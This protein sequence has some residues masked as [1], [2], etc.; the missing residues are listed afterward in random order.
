MK[1]PIEIK[2]AS[3][4]NLIA[5]GAVLILVLILGYAQL[6]T[7]YVVGIFWLS[8][9]GIIMATS[10]NLCNGFLGQMALGHAGF[11]LIG[12]YTSALLSLAM[13]RADILAG[14][15]LQQFLR[16]VICLF[17]SG[18]LATIFGILVGIPALRLRG[19]YLAIITL[20]FGEIIRVVIQG[21]PWAGADGLEQGSAS[22]V[23]YKTGLGFN[24]ATKSQYMVFIALLTILCVAIIF[25]FIRSRF[26]RA[27]ISIRDDEI[28]S[29]ASGID[30]TRYKVMGFAFSAFFAGIAGS[31]FAACY[32][33]LNT[34]NMGFMAS[35]NYFVMV[36]FGGMGSI[37][38][39][40]VSAIGLTTLNESLR[41]FNE[42]RMLVYSVVL[43][44]MMIFRPTGLLGTY[45]FSLTQMLKKFS[46][47]SAKKS[48]NEEVEI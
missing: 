34:G 41:S 44:L 5:C 18:L 4:I 29:E 33:S 46:G 26:G 22:P 47:G 7:S 11:M 1:M 2:K 36:V 6:L 24:N 8:C 17:A 3:R 27:V 40:I 15:G 42:Y 28:A 31:I 13:V 32:S 30:T 25:T 12:A 38:G 21:I 37:T 43:V 19:D 45:E 9:I 16:F 14:D 20:G 10:L 23:L 48:K 35:V 39:S